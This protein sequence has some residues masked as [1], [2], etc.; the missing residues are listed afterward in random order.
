[1]SLSIYNSNIQKFLFEENAPLI[2]RIEY[3][4]INI[5]ELTTTFFDENSGW[6]DSTMLKNIG[7]D[8]YISSLSMTEPTYEL[9]FVESTK[10]GKTY[11]NYATGYGSNS[12]FDLLQQSPPWT[13]IDDAQITYGN[14]FSYNIIPIPELIPIPFYISID[15]ID[16][17]GGGGWEEYV[18][19]INVI[20]NDSSSVTITSTTED[21]NNGVQNTTPTIVTMTQDGNYQITTVGNHGCDNTNRPFLRVIGQ[22]TTFPHNTE[23]IIDIL[24]CN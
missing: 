18:F 4:E 1:M 21:T 22:D 23:D 7:S 14:Q 2:K 10:Q 24:F 19:Q 5:W 11:I 8:I 9:D 3:S 17:G 20:M 15:V 16:P 6:T 13:N 12:N